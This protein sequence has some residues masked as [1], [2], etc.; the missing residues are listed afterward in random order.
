MD[1][2]GYIEKLYELA[3]GSGTLKLPCIPTRGVV[4]LP[5]SQTVFEI[6]RRKSVF[7]AR[8]ALSDNGLVFLTAQREEE[9]ERPASADQLSTVGTVCS[10]RQLVDTAGNIMRCT[11]D[12]I[13]RAKMTDFSARGNGYRA[14]IEL[15]PNYAEDNMS[16]NDMEA[17][18]RELKERYF[19]FVHSA[20]NM[21]DYTPEE[22]YPDDTALDVY[23]AIAFTI[24]MG[25]ADK[26]ELNTLNTLFEKMSLLSVIL[27]KETDINQ[28]EAQIHETV[29]NA[30]NRNQREFYIREQINALQNELG[31]G[32]MGDMAEID[33]FRS[34]LEAIQHID[35]DSRSKIAEEIDRYAHMPAF[36]QEASTLRSYIDTV[37]TMPWDSVSDETADVKKAEK[38]LDEDHYGLE[39][40]KQRV[41]ENIAVRQISPEVKGQIICLYGP[42]GVGKTSVAKSIARA[43]DRKYVR[44]ALG[45]VR[46][47]SEI[48]GH[49][50]TYVGSMPGR[51]VAALRQVG[52]R[53]PVMLLDE[54]DK[55]SRDFRGDPSSALLE[56]LDSEQNVTF[57]DH[58]TE[59]AF[60]LSDVLFITT[61][62]SL[63]TIDPPLLDRM[64]IIELSSYTREEKFNIA[65]KHLIPKQLKKFGLRSSQLKIA[66]TAIYAMIDSYTREAGVRKLEQQIAALCRKSA[67]KLVEGEEKVTIK[68]GNIDSFLGHKKHTEDYFIKTPSVG[69]VNGLAWTSVG[70]VI[71]PLEVLVLDGKG[72]TQL[73]GSLG[74]VM[75]ESA[76]LAVSNARQ[77]AEKY[78]ID[79]DFYENKDIHI[80]APEGATPKDG[81]SAGVTMVTAL[82][83]ALSGIKVR[84][85][86]AM[87]GEITLTGK[88]LP[89]GGLREKTMA[90]YKAG[91]KTVVIPRANEGDLDEVENIV[92]QNVE[93]RL[94]DTIADVLNTALITGEEKSGSAD[95]EPQTEQNDQKDKAV[96][97]RRGRPSSKKA[98]VPQPTAETVTEAGNV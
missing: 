53:N 23:E 97:R 46:D 41:L 42:P 45:G 81:P 92:K 65:K 77:F 44:V 48:R 58:Y 67:R 6:G 20:N 17:L 91:M 38:V 9:L 39:K 10:V 28:L 49:R 8:K 18:K 30:V 70:G 3:D 12:G 73:T 21:T 54:I 7:A 22:L 51:I 27:L 36:S 72:K 84:P 37:L 78:G 68:S 14:E 83:S 29:Q 93:F 32:D 71:M 16:A 59:V 62:N 43:L 80:H 85:D 31:E 96:G 34:K 11:V 4:V 74:D 19:E 66:D 56:V 52:V 55:I 61:A 25:F 47:E 76:Q 95:G 2:K 33:N 24:P 64:E 79:K 89:I 50:K 35:D 98:P 40:V 94:A 69:C 13:A 82:I 57:R 26:Q 88:V 15:L 90:A 60:D 87:T 75:K 5:G 86:V 1:N 63:D